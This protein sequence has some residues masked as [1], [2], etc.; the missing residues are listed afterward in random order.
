MD[1]TFHLKQGQQLLDKK[2]SQSIKKALEH[3]RE[4]NLG[5][6]ENNV[7]KPKIL[8]FLALGNYLIGQVGQAYRIAY[9]AKRS[10]DFAM[11]SSVFVMDN[12][13]QMLGEKDIEDMIA[14]IESNYFW[15][16]ESI[17]IEDDDFD[18]NILDFSNLHQIYKSEQKEEIV[19]TFEIE[20]LSDELLS[21]TFYGMCRTNDELIYFDKLKGDVLGYVEGFLSSH[22]GDQNVLNNRLS[23]RIIYRDNP[24]Y[25]D[26]DRYIL[27]DQLP[28][29]EFLDEIKSNS[30]NNDTYLSFVEEF[31]IT[32]LEDFKYYDDLSLDDLGC[33]KHI[34]YKFLELFR[35]YCNNNYYEV[36]NEF[37]KIINNSQHSLARSW[38][39]KKISNKIKVLEEQLK[40]M[41][42]IERYTLRRNCAQ[43]GDLKLLLEIA[44]YHFI[45]G[46]A[47]TNE[48]NF[49]ELC[50][51]YGRLGK[52][53]ELKEFLSDKE[54]YLFMLP[55]SCRELSE[56][57]F[58]I[59]MKFPHL[60][61][62]EMS[63]LDDKYSNS[64]TFALFDIIMFDADQ[65]P[66]PLKKYDLAQLK[67]RHSEFSENFLLEVYDCFSK[68][69]ALDDDSKLYV[70]DR[71][72]NSIIKKRHEDLGLTEYEIAQPILSNEFHNLLK[73][74]FGESCAIELSKAVCFDKDLE[75]FISAD[76]FLLSADSI[77]NSAMEYFN[78]ENTVSVLKCL[79][80]QIWLGK[81]NSKEYEF[82]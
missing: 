37:Y 35:F 58:D 24:D 15:E 14:H 60:T 65:L 78:D 76:Y 38:I 1:I 59:G 63:Y 61:E 27:I 21:A 36:S 46:S 77:V 56:R 41:D 39:K 57:L 30:Q 64:K 17:D 50:Y 32:I 33:S 7:L 43:N 42:A 62:S 45:K 68:N 54:F 22:L 51:Y 74:K 72:N 52:L 12:M 47:A 55:E 4:A 19:P 73:D 69:E 29:S 6:D 71:V 81:V 25:I 18:E 82:V 31:S 40:S 2:D 11:Q 13:R 79:I 26:E 80:S 70:Y 49:P 8:Y 10:I 48:N 20:E 66:R 23:N 28:L 53:E 44:E 3:F 67:I 5:N 16:I 9:K 34:L 75:H